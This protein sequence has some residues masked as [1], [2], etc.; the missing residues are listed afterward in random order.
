MGCQDYN[1]KHIIMITSLVV[2]II[3]ISNCL[4]EYMFYC[5]GYNN[6]IFNSCLY[7]IGIMRFEEERMGNG[8]E[9]APCRA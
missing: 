8:P 2:S 1:V 3:I 6:I 7:M 9:G 5:E 4:L